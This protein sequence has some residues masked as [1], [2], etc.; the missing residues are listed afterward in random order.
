MKRNKAYIKLENVSKIF[1][2]SGQKVLQD[3]NFEVQKGEF[4]CIVGGSGCGKSTL[5][6][7]MSGLDADY[8]GTVIVDGEKITRPSKL[9]GFVF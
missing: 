3:I 5:L 2:I 8:A 7:T 9:R 6:R 4:I 1:P